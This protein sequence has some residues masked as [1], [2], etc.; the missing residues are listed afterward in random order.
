MCAHAMTCHIFC[1]KKCTQTISLEYVFHTT[2]VAPLYTFTYMLLV[3]RNIKCIKW[4]KMTDVW[5]PHVIDVKSTL[6]TGDVLWQSFRIFSNAIAPN[7]HYVTFNIYN[8]Y[9]HI[10]ISDAYER[11]LLGNV[12]HVEKLYNKDVKLLYIYFSVS[13]S[14]GLF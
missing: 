13:F 10:Y 7:K 9:L 1:F 12:L 5:T 6:Y 2:Q 8:S 14:S 4:Y 11:I 3:F